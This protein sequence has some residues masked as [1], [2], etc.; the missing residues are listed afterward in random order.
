MGRFF[1]VYGSVRLFYYVSLCVVEYAVL[2][3]EEH[4][5]TDDLRTLYLVIGDLIE[6]EVLA[7]PAPCY[8]AARTYAACPANA[9][10]VPLKAHILLCVPKSA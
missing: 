10:P 6:T 8:T 4:T 7:S 1:C 2:L 9:V 3:D 5:V